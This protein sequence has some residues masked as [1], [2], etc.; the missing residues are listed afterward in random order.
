V[1][2]THIRVRAFEDGDLQAIF[3][4][5]RC[6]GVVYSTLQMPFQSLDAVR[7]RF[8]KSDPNLYQLVGETEGRVV[9]TL[10]LLVSGGRRRHAGEIGMAV[11]DDYQDRGLGTALMAAVVDLADNWL[12]L[13]RL[14]L[15]VYA[16]NA[17]AIHLYE[18]FGFTIEGTKRKLALREGS[19]VDAYVMGRV[20]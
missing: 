15:E 1:T 14:D 19:Y 10:G 11:H 7:E 8:G 4:I 2:S 20:R 12:G 6:P 9:G 18:K 16:D 5:M 13:T 17:A 3:E